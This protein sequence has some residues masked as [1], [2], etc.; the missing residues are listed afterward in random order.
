MIKVS[1]LC[2]AYNEVENVDELFETFDKFNQSQNYLWELVFVDDGSNDGTYKKAFELSKKFQNI[3]VLKHKKN[4]GK[5]A[6]ILTAKEISAGEIFVIY[7]ADMQY[8]FD[9]CLKL[10][11]RI[12]NDDFD[13]CTGWKQGKYKKAFVSKIYNYLSRKFFNLP[14]HDQNGLKAFKKEVLDSIHLRRDWHRY[15][16]SLAIEKG[17]SVTEEKVTLYPRKHGISKY[18]SSFRILIGFF[19][20]LTVKFLTT[21]LKKPMIFFGISGGILFI[22]GFLIGIIALI[23]RLFFGFGFRPIL[24]LVI[25]LII[26]GL[27]MFILGFVSELLSI[28]IE[29]IEELKK[30]L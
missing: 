24:Y 11:K 15:I 4:L 30:K 29:D 1:V 5:T 13:I 25:L 27:L 23:V 28:V 16:V 20:L 2:S 17:F 26:S 3:K 6:G 9:D 14:I 22:L 21:F 10:V 18:S 7:D 12:E 8:S 19:D